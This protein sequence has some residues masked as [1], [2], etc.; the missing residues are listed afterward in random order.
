MSW[1]L[2][3]SAAVQRRVLSRPMFRQLA[4]CGLQSILDKYLEEGFAFL[5]Q[6]TAEEVATKGSIDLRM[7][8]P[9]HVPPSKKWL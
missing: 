4:Y 6:L 3:A 5:N 9:L 1:S 7:P 8:S 2:Y